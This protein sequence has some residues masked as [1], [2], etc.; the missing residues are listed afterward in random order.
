MGRRSSKRT[1]REDP[2]FESPSDA[3]LERFGD[4]SVACTSCGASIYD[5]VSVCPKCL[6]PIASRRSSARPPLWLIIV[7]GLVVLAM[8]APSLLSFL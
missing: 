3:D 6:M 7:L 8:T 1:A 2:D 5:D 4:E